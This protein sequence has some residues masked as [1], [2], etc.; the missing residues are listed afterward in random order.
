[1]IKYRL[2]IQVATHWSPL[3]ACCI[4]DHFIEIHYKVV[5]RGSTWWPK[6]KL[7][8]LRQKKKKKKE[9]SRTLI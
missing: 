3:A 2:I 8:L 1:M 9:N 5:A 7:L 6:F 4:W